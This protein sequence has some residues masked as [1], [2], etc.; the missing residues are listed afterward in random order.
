M[1]EAKVRG[2]ILDITTVHL[3]K[4]SDEE[5]QQGK[6]DR[7]D[8]VVLVMRPVDRH[9]CVHNNEPPRVQGAYVVKHVTDEVSLL[10]SQK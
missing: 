1:R 10:G 8:G 5:E 9:C 4:E 2:G 3:I 7:S 6:L